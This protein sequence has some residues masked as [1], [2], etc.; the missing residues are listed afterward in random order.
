MVA[1]IKQMFKPR[2][3]KLAL[4]ALLIASFAFIPFLVFVVGQLTTWSL[5]VLAD[6][7]IQVVIVEEHHEGNSVY[8]DCE[9]L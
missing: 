6:V 3:R 8:R 9:C 5:P 1:V 7:D 4:F 2:R